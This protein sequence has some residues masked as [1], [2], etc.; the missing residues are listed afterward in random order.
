MKLTPHYVPF[1]KSAPPKA[2]RALGL[3]I[4]ITMALAGVAS[5]LT[6]DEERTA[7]GGQRLEVRCGE[8]QTVSWTLPQG[9]ER[10][11]VLEPVAG[12]AVL[13]GFG[14]KRLG[15][16]QGVAQR[17][18]GS[19]RTVVDVTVVGVGAACDGMGLAWETGP[20]D[21]RARYHVV[22]DVPVVVSDEQAGMHPRERPGRLTANADAG[23]RSLRWRS[24]GG[25]RAVARGVFQ[26][27]RWVPIGHTDVVQRTFRYPVAVSLSRIRVC[28]AGRHHYTR[29]RTRFLTHAPVSVRRQAR[30]PATAGCLA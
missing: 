13:D 16:V 7:Q 23:W 20:V 30:P 6:V 17:S 3:G 25:E 12:Q 4:V 9:A 1:L 19:G 21:F 11:E 26:V 2:L 5:A 28:G 18:D 15:T 8:P 29:I 14:D 10:V 27:R 22:S 24:W